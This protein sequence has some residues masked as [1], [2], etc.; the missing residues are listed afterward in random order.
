MN[1]MMAN[2]DNSKVLRMVRG[3]GLAIILG[4]ACGCGQD[5]TPT[6]PVASAKTPAGSDASGANVAGNGTPQTNSGQPTSATGINPNSGVVV[7]PDASVVN[8]TPIG[9][10][11]NPS[12]TGGSG[13]NNWLS[14]LLTSLGASSTDSSNANS[15]LNSVMSSLGNGTSSTPSSGSGGQPTPET[16]DSLRQACA[17]AINQYRA[18]MGSSP[19]TLKAD[20]AT[21]SCIDGQASGDG[22]GFMAHLHFGACGETAQDECPGWPGD[23]GSSQTGCLQAMWA[24]G[25][26]GG[27]YENMSNSGYTQVACGFALVNGGWWMTQDFF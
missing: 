3:I 6:P 9:V 8:N 7:S 23:P 13:S 12:T 1:D 4:L 15:W 11:S 22:S 14:S 18:S 5:K 24:E 25:P 21:N 16:L 20:S 19:L 2:C 17:D 27:H 26:G 10:A